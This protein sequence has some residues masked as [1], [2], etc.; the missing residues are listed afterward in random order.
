MQNKR[1]VKKTQENPGGMVSVESPVAYANVSLIDPVTKSPV[2]VTWRYLEDGTKVRVTRG[3][4]AS[5]SV[6][7]RPEILGQRRKPR[8]ATLG[9]SDTT[10]DVASEE[11]FTGPGEL[12]TAL[13]EFMKDFG[14]GSPDAPTRFRYSKRALLM[15]PSASSDDAGK[16]SSSR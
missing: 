9:T 13:K 14:H 1:A 16:T 6:I 4:L 8:P 15:S 5:G 11:T 2:K 7:P 12:P 3:N 10:V